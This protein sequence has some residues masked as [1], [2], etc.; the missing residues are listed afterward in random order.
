MDRVNRSQIARIKETISR[1]KDDKSNTLFREQGITIVSILTAFSLAISTIVTSSVRPI[2]IPPTPVPP[3]PSSGG[4]KE[5]IQKTQKNISNLLKK[6]GLKALDALL[7]IIGGV[8]SWL[9]STL[10]KA[11]GWLAEH[12]YLFVTGVGMMVVSLYTK[13]TKKQIVN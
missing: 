3:T 13:S 10:S 2:P 6:L 4:V 1:F 12:V 9:L 7:G 11:V 8:L 5:C